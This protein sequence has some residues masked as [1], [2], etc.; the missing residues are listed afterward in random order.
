[1]TTQTPTLVTMGEATDKESVAGFVEEVLDGSG[2]TLTRVK[3]RSSR[4]EPPDS[5]WALFDIAINKDEEE[6]RLRLVAKGALNPSAWN[7]LSA[8]LAT[9]EADGRCDPIAGLGY[10]R[11]FPE[12]QHAY[13]FYPFDPAMP[14]LSEAADHVRMARLLVGLGDD[15][16]AEVLKMARRLNIERVRYMPEIGAILRYRLNGPGAQMDIYGKVQ[17]GNRG[18]RT[19]RIVTAL[20]Q[21]AQN[22]PGYLKLPRQ[23]GFVDQ[24]GLLLEERVRGLPVGGNRAN[25][26]FRHL[27]HAAAEA[28]A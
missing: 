27:G 17:P 26:E 2:W 4:L 22:H 19:H 11:L 14:G 1:M 3:R 16:T 20:W 9:H 10:P 7:R 24:L 25:I 5:Y 23:L 28:L 12:S 15:N 13:W 8:Q 21:A 18:L 6:R